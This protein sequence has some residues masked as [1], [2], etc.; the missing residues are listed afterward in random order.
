M[1]ADN[2][3]YYGEKPNPNDWANLMEED[4][5]LEEELNEVFINAEIP[6]DHDYTPG[7]LEDTYLI[8]ELDFGKGWGVTQMFKSD[9]QATW[10]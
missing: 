5:E 2:R 8:M 6:G 10:F 4:P 1:K 9:Q 7:V 3:G